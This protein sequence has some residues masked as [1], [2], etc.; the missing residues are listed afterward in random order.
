[1]GDGGSTSDGGGT[2]EL[3]EVTWRG[4]VAVVQMRH[5]EN[6]FNR[7]SVGAL[8]EAYGD[9]A[10]RDGPLA[11]VTT[12]AD[13]F[14][15]NGLDLDWMASEGTDASSAFVDEVHAL[16]G[17]VL[18]LPA[19]T[20]AAV[21]GHAFAA[22]AMLAATHDWI[23]MRDDRGYWCIPEVDLGLPLTPA[24]YAALASRLP[25]RTLHEASLDG[26]RYTA[27]EAVAAGIAD[28][29]VPEAEVVDR[30]VAIATPLAGK[31]RRVIATHKQLLHAEALAVI[32]GGS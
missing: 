26:R 3:V 1:M 15:S 17:Q 20:V 6:R 9:L 8:R 18:S 19:V 21:N 27:A 29:A 22:G 24:M 32:A 7:R 30:A 13:R 23:V 10:G 14:F 11:V 4:D 31:D 25:K 28:E 5:G 12:G 16:L 2:G